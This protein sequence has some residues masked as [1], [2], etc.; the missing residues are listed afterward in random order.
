MR[1]LLFVAFT[2]FGFSLVMGQSNSGE[3]TLAPQIGVNFST[4]SSTDASY[5][6]RTSF[7]GGVIGEYYFSDRWSFRS[8]LLY[9]AMGAKDSF[10]NIDKLN[11]VTIPLNANWHFGKNRNW[12]LNFGPAI[13]ILLNAE[14]ELNNG[15][16]VDIKDFVSGLDVGLTLGIGYKFDINDDF[17]LSIDYQGFGGIIN[18]DK[19]NTL[20]F[21]VR[22]SRSSINIGGIFKL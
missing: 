15:Q 6:A 7:A 12:F 21:D 4:Y 13:A 19:E 9:D 11:Y 22:N 16:I 2:V 8:G 20:P 5:D 14:S 3:F 10:D 17:Q 1:K 18:I